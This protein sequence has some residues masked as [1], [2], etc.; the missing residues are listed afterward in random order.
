[1]MEATQWKTV[2][3]Q[4]ELVPSL[5]PVAQFSL[6]QLKCKSVGSGSCGAL[7]RWVASTTPAPARRSAEGREGSPEQLSGHGSSE[8]AGKLYSSALQTR[9]PQQKRWCHS[10]TP[11]PPSPPSLL[12][13]KRSFFSLFFLPGLSR[14]PMMRTRKEP[15]ITLYL[16]EFLSPCCRSYSCYIDGVHK[17]LVNV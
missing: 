11:P 15:V 14:R 16:F 3:V 5:P 17:R 4:P 7:Q 1:M 9:Q 2:E 13:H 12:L 8:G 6:D 10:S